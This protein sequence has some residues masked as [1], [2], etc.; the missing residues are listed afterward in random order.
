MTTTNEYTEIDRSIFVQCSEQ[1]KFDEFIFGDDFNSKNAMSSFEVGGQ[2]LD[3]HLMAKDHYTVADIQKHTEI[4]DE[5]LT[6]EQ[7]E[8]ICAKFLDLQISRIQGHCILTNVLTSVYIQKSYQIKNP[9]LNLIF[10]LFSHVCLKIEEFTYE[11]RFNASFWSYNSKYATFF[12]HHDDSQLKQEFEKISL[13]PGLKQIVDF[14]FDLSQFLDDPF[15]N[16]MNPNFE[17]PSQTNEIG[18]DKF[19]HYRDATPSTPPS[20]PQIPDHEQA[21]KLLHQF[22]NEINEFSQRFNKEFRMSELIDALANWNEEADR[23]SLSRFVLIHR[24]LTKTTPDE[25]F[26]SVSPTQ[27][28][29]NELKDFNVNQKFFNHKNFPSFLDLFRT[30]FV[31]IVQHLVVPIPTGHSY[32]CED[33]LRYWGYIQSQGFELHCEAVPEVD[34]PK[35]ISKEHQKAAAMVFP[36][37][38]TQIAAQLLM[39]NYRWGYK[40]EVYSLRD[41]HI[42]L[43]CAQVAAKMASISYNQARIAAAVYRVRSNK[44]TGTWHRKEADVIRM[45]HDK[46]P[47]ELFYNAIDELFMGC[48]KIVRMLK[49]YK[50]LEI[51]EG[52]FFNEKGVFETRA[53]PFS[54]ALHFNQQN[55]SD[56]EKEMDLKI[57]QDNTKLMVADATKSLTTAKEYVMQ[58]LKA[59]GKKSDEISGMMRC[60]VANSIFLSR[61]NQSQKVKVSY[62]HHFMWPVFEVIQ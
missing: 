61:F 37:W 47:T 9:I 38:S 52:L 36:F 60:L 54:M 53:F 51:K 31:Q 11:L 45:I 8:G 28:M 12:D 35:C 39:L 29:K 27:Y 10:R 46:S 16:T 58:Y 50:C 55:F 7:I 24:I 18:L 57:F 15:K 62:E 4:P 17:I 6:I 30:V 25:F 14:E 13:S 44:K 34:H 21:I 33:G 32:L 43:Y 20:R 3:A 48:F 41:I 22:V 5:S 1:L 23:V 40:S 49:H 42:T 56:F 2:R 19:L 26:H 59:V